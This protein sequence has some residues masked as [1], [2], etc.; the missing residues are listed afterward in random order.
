MCRTLSLARDVFFILIWYIKI[1]IQFSVLEFLLLIFINH[2][3]YI[4]LE[5]ALSLNTNLKYLTLTFNDDNLKQEYGNIIYSLYMYQFFYCII[6]Y[7]KRLQIEH[8][9]CCSYK[10][11]HKALRVYHVYIS[12]ADRPYRRSLLTVSISCRLK[13]QVSE[14]SN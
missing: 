11:L 6:D 14:Y 7:I 8:S 12:S 13:W 1:I 2:V 10:Y 5:W 9:L 4:L 3:Y